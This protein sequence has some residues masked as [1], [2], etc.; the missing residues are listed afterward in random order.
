M[1]I[2][3]I[4]KPLRDLGETPG[5]LTLPVAFDRKKFAAK[6]VLEGPA[7][8]AAAE[9][10]YIPGTHMT[11]DGWDVWRSPEGKPHK[12]ALQSGVHVL[13]CRSKKVQDAV[14]AICGNVGKSRLSQERTGETV[15]GEQPTDPGILN[16]ARIAQVEGGERLEEGDIRPNPV[17]SGED[18]RRVTAPTLKT[19][20][21]TVRIRRRQ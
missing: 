15:A 16:D 20:S 19:K 8:D 9:R 21:S 13:L 12:V 2:E 6:W 5:P 1:A 17:E 3:I 14:N 4:S 18:S 11:A 7:V 10:Q